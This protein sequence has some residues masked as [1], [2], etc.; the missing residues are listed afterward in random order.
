MCPY[1]ALCLSVIAACSKVLKPQ[2][3]NNTILDTREEKS[4]D[5]FCRFMKYVAAKFKF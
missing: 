1:Y 4:A 3:T 5:N 2:T